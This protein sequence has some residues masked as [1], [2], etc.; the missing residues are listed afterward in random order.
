MV[1]VVDV[2]DGQGGG[3]FAVVARA[4]GRDPLVAGAGG[5]VVVCGGGWI[6][7]EV[8]AA[9]RDYGC[10]V[11]VVEPSA[12]LRGNGGHVSAV[13]SDNSPGQR[14]SDSSSGPEPEPPDRRAMTSAV[15]V[16]R[17]TL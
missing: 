12:T 17:F 8:A 15:Q 16:P 6:G 1:V 7:M 11:T 13:V 10:H 9:A 14:L 3:G 5:R 2:P 4:V